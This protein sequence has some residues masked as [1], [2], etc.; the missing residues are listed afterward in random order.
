MC[1]ERIFPLLA[2]LYPSLC[3][4]QGGGKPSGRSIRVND[5]FVVKYDA[6][7]R[8]RHLPLHVDQSDLSL[9]VALNAQEIKGGE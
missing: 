3:G 4:G 9:T 7:S 6:A 5:A 8:Q 1:R 2:R